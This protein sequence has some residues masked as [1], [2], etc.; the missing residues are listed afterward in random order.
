MHHSL[1]TPRRLHSF[2]TRRSS[3]LAWR[4][5]INEEGEVSD[6]IVEEHDTS[7]ER[8]YHQ[9]VK[10]VSEDY[11]N[12]HF[13]TAISQMMV[14]VNEGYKVEKI[15]KQ[16]IEGFVKLLYPIAPHIG[17]ELWNRLG[18]EDTITYEDWPTYDKTKLVEEEVEVVLQ[19]MG[20]VRSK[21]KVAKDISKE[22]LEQVALENERIQQWIEGKTI[23]KVIVVP[24][25]LVNIV[26][27]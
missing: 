25:K 23:R 2:P 7:M 17:E 26:A 12:L 18:H 1:P 6:K 13:N 11:D 22:E 10:K 19:V 4:L 20:K 5:V 9:T 27:N 21:I 14:F 15:S 16:F 8:I 3:D 24:G